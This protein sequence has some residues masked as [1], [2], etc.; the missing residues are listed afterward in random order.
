LPGWVQRFNARK[1]PAQ[2]AGKLWTPLLPLDQYPEPDSVPQENAG[3]GGVTFP[4]AAPTDP[5]Q[6]AAVFAA[7]PWM[8]ELTLQFALDGLVSM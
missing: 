5:A 2:F 8:D 6:A 7:F 3:R 4:H 1:I